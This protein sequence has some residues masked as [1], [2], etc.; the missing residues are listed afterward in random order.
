MAIAG[1]TARRGVRSDARSD[2]PSGVRRPGS[3]HHDTAAVTF[4]AL[5]LFATTQGPVYSL[6]NRT[7]TPWDAFAAPASITAT[8]IVLTAIVLHLLDREPGA[9]RR[10]WGVRSAL[11]LATVALVALSTIWST[12]RSVTF[13]SAVSLASMVVCA[14]WF[15]VRL[16]V[17]QQVTAVLVAM[18]AG[19]WISAFAIWREWPGSLDPDKFWA[20][21]Y[22]NPN[23]LAPVAAMCLL[24]SVYV[25]RWQ[26]LDLRAGAR[27]WPQATWRLVLLIAGDVVAV[28]MLMHANSETSTMLL[29]IV[30]VVLLLVMAARRLRARPEAVAGAILGCIAALSIVGAR[31]VDSISRWSERGPD[32]SGRTT[33]W[34]VAVDGYADRPWFGWGFNAAWYDP[35]FRPALAKDPTLVNTIYAAHNGFLEVL[36]GVGPLGVALIVG[37]LVGMLVVVSRQVFADRR[38][39]TW[40]MA[41]V[42]F[43]LVA[44]IAE[45]FITGNH[46]IWLLLAAAILTPLDGSGRAAA[47]EDVADAAGDPTIPI[48]AA[49]AVEQPATAG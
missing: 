25:L 14:A 47:D 20:G 48:G 18:Q 35:T 40:P 11:L 10:L 43:T 8:F 1:V 23:S 39:S 17:R 21:I 41:V 44:N 5:V 15:Q 29:T 12:A 2:A 24:A 22:Y 9:V 37:A 28:R 49:P 19:L 31:L 27:R 26:L 7:A 42:A 33:I 3:R 32:L 36:L 6:W 34:G 30:P 4:A 16:R 46:F 45:T 13:T 38:A